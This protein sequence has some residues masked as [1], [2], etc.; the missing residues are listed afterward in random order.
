SHLV[1][2]LQTLGLEFAG[3]YFHRDIHG[4]VIMVIMSEVARIAPADFD[5]RACRRN[6]CVEAARGS[7]L[8]ITLTDRREQ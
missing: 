4:H 8:T 3:R 1:H 6:G 5:A 7:H 2:Q